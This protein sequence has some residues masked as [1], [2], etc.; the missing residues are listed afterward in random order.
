MWLLAYC[1]RSCG[2]LSSQFRNANAAACRSPIVVYGECT[3][4]LRTVEL[5]LLESRTPPPILWPNYTCKS[6]RQSSPD[7]LRTEGPTSD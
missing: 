1:S 5:S 6:R 4:Q 2:L 7:G 3:G